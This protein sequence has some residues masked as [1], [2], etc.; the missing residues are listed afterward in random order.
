MARQT[1][2]LRS[3]SASPRGCAGASALSPSGSS[4]SFAPL[5]ISDTTD[6]ADFTT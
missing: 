3:T 5:A 4:A 6:V 1:G 2:I